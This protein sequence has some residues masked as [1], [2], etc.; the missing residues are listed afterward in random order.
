MYSELVLEILVVLSG[1]IGLIKV[2]TPKKEKQI[3]YKVE[4][5]LSLP[6]EPNVIDFFNYYDRGQDID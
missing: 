3:E 5:V 4:E 6:A 2:N 1:A